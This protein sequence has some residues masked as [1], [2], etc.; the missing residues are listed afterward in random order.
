MGVGVH[1]R[2]T[3]GP[4]RYEIWTMQSSWH[5]V[6]EVDV[7]QQAP[8][9]EHAARRVQGLLCP[10]AAELSMD[11]AGAYPPEAGIRVPGADQQLQRSKCR[12]RG[13]RFP[14]G[15]FR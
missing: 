6:P 13:H 1:T 10:G 3:F 4:E 8:G 2:Q 7:F 14:S 11:L 9:R 15:R 12:V 5:N